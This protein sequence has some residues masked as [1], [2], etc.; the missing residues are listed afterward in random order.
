MILDEF[1]RLE[2]IYNEMIEYEIEDQSPN[3]LYLVNSVHAMV[4][5]SH[6]EF[7]KANEVARRNLE[8]AKQHGYIGL[9]A[10]ID[11]MYV[12]ARAALAGAKN[13][14]ALEIFS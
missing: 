12:M 1:D 13:K 11:S 9:M 3:L 4:L 7:I 2:S 14:E 10:P 6:G 5:M 8:I